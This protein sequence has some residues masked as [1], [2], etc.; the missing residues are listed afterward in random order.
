M[1]MICAW[2]IQHYDVYFSPAI[3]GKGQAA[4]TRL[5]PYL[6]FGLVKIILIAFHVL[7]IKSRSNLE[8]VT[9]QAII[10][11]TVH[12]AQCQLDE[13][14]AESKRERDLSVEVVLELA[15]GPPYPSEVG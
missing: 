3:I 6:S 11:I 7:S 5:L 1:Q 15:P 13:K 12:A 10:H 8:S 9:P 2:F 4:E 14:K